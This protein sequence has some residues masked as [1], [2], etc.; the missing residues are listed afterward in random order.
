MA[1]RRPWR[2]RRRQHAVDRHVSLHARAIVVTLAA[3]SQ[4]EYP[5]FECAACRS[6]AGRPPGFRRKN[7]HFRRA[8][9]PMLRIVDVALRHVGCAPRRKRA[10][11]ITHSRGLARSL[12]LEHVDNDV[13]QGS[14]NKLDGTQ[15]QL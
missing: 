6:N 1:A 12:I 2:R 15:I 14:K 8:V 7:A 11:L 10:Q 13:V 9:A 5:T 3:S 4:T